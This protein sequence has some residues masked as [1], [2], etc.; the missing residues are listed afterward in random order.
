MIK[1][2]DKMIQVKLFDCSHE[3]DLEEEM[4]EF[5]KEMEGEVLNIKYQTQFLDNGDDETIYSFSAMVIYK[6]GIKNKQ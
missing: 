6:I 3:L 1:Q 2:G 4:N 5:F